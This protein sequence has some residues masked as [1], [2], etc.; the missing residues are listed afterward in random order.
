MNRAPTAAPPR[1][2]ITPL[3]DVRVARP[4][5]LWA[6][7]GPDALLASLSPAE[8][9]RAARFRFDVDR[10][11]YIAAHHLLRTALAERLGSADPATVALRTGPGGRPELAFDRG[12]SFNLSHTRGMVACALSGAAAVGVDVEGVRPLPDLAS[13]AR[14]VLTDVE[15]RELMTH[16][17]ALRSRAFM[18]R[19]TAKE[20]Y[21]KAT[22]QGLALPLSAIAVVDA[23]RD[24]PVIHDAATGRR[25]PGVQI[26][27]TALGPGH[28]LA[29]ATITR[30]RPR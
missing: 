7:P 13:L 19:W 18:R 5:D 1:S 11:A 3:V 30:G 9:D 25:L 29:V 28:L 15:A 21:A 16:P 8:V 2:G 17:P 20:A 27:V 24:R 26:D 6:S 22:G 10:R 14:S 4:E 12:V 23:D